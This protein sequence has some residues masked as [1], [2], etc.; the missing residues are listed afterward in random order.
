MSVSAARFFQVEGVVLR[1]I[2][3]WPISE[4]HMNA[5]AITHTA[6]NLIILVAATVAEIAF[7][8]VN[9]DDLPLVCDSFCPSSTKMVTAMKVLLLTARR[10]R[11]HKVL[12][13]LRHLYLA[14]TDA[15]NIAINARLSHFSRTITLILATLTSATCCSYV[16]IP[17]GKYLWAKHTGGETLRELPFKSV[18]PYDASQ[19]PVYEI[20]Y[21]ILS[22]SGY[23]TAA[24]IIGMDGLFVGLCLHISG[25]FQIIQTNINTLVDREIGVLNCLNFLYSPPAAGQIGQAEL[26]CSCARMYRFTLTLAFAAPLLTK[27]P[28]QDDSAFTEEQSRHIY[29]RL[30]AFVR[31]QDDTIKLCEEM[32]KIFQPNILMHFLSAAFV[33]CFS[34]VNLILS[35]G[36]A[37]FLYVNYIGAA[38]TQLFVYS[39]GGSYISTSSGEICNSA[40]FF[41][42]YKSNKDVRRLLLMLMTRA[43][44]E[45]GV[46]VPFF[47]AS[48]E[49]FA[50]ILR[51]AGSYIALLKTFL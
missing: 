31:R 7:G 1:F 2:G 44:R 14:E 19:S 18:F 37:I 43:Q 16:F 20:T 17:I 50:T 22:Y 28:S 48:L 11:V 13:T 8:I 21:I 27:R 15:E 24:G 33:I 42:W 9:I 41:E 3:M 38:T 26:G 25:Q 51:T 35:S 36:L 34:S 45:S 49:T 40:Y 47:Q 46:F 4:R 23:I 32:V 29:H 12:Q 5:R 10:R 39:I 6:I 30:S